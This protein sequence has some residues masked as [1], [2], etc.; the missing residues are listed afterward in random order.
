ME[1][2]DF[3]AL[4]E[5]L[6]LSISF[7]VLATGGLII[8]LLSTRSSAQK[9]IKDLAKHPLNYSRALSI[10][11][12]CIGLIAAALFP[13]IPIIRPLATEILLCMAIALFVSGALYL[14]ATFDDPRYWLMSEAAQQLIKPWRKSLVEDVLKDEK[15]A[16][17]V[18]NITDKLEKMV[19]EKLPFSGPLKS[20]SSKAVIEI[21]FTQY[22]VEESLQQL[23]D[24]GRCRRAKGKDKKYELI[25]AG[26]KLS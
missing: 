21:S 8:E 26:V 23:I 4:V 19:N 3:S 11:V 17:T 15:T 9:S 24:E 5:S 18:P 20:I 10:T 1:P 25:M 12:L 13:V 7:L 2:F 22:L 16:L 6:K 14:Q